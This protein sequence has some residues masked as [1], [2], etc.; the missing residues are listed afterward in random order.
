MIQGIREPQNHIPESYKSDISKV[1]STSENVP[2][3]LLGDEDKGVVWERG[4]AQGK[5]TPRTKT[6]SRSGG[7]TNT[8]FSKEKVTYT[9]S[10][11]AKALLK[12]EE[13][14]AQPREKEDKGPSVFSR[15][16]T[17]IKNFFGKIFSFIWYGKE[18]EKETKD[19]ASGE[20][21]TAD[22]VSDNVKAAT[23]KKTDEERIK[24]YIKAGNTEG[25]VDVLTRGGTVLPARNTTLLTQYDRRGH[26]A[27]AG[28][29]T[30]VILHG[31]KPI[32]L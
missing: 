26:I 3:F 29:N 27:E 32:E 16:A 23:I 11:E 17:G 18:D 6:P 8:T 5:N 28:V 30:G 25:V 19:L 31:D 15:V 20:E 9:P 1:K 7:V 13:P 4:A 22:S 14:I 24:E 10:R 2:K 12:K 21:I